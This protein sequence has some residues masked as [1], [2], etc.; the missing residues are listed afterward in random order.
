V[1]TDAEQVTLTR[2]EDQIAWYDRQSASAQTKYK[3]LKIVNVVAAA[4]VPVTALLQAPALVPAGLGGL[5]VVLEAVQHMNQ[6]QATW[7]AYRSNCEALKHEKYLFLAR[8]GPYAAAANPGALLAERIESLVSQEHA[9]WA[10]TQEQASRGTRPAPGG[11][12]RADG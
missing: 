2:L 4:L 7:I 10:S 3:A 6:Y 9:K 8:A 11:P 12:A 1:A 5:I